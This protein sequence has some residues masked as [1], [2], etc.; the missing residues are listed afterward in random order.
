[1]APPY[2]SVRI[3]AQVFAAS[4]ALS[5][6]VSALTLGGGRKVWKEGAS[7]TD[8]GGAGLCRRVKTWTGGVSRAAAQR[9]C[10]IRKIPVRLILPVFHPPPPRSGGYHPSSSDSRKTTFDHILLFP[11]SYPVRVLPP[12]RVRLYPVTAIVPAGWVRHRERHRVL[13]NEPVLYTFTGVVRFVFVL[14]HW[15]CSIR[16]SGRLYLFQRLDGSV[17]GVT[18]IRTR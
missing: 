14:V 6:R 2:D 17:V 8:E 12:H 16:W 11:L 9:P 15:S 3:G 4:A 7:S 1:V 13:R 10:L 18:D 5:L